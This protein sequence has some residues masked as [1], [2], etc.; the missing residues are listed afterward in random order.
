[1]VP[2]KHAGKARRAGLT[3]LSFSW[4]AAMGVIAAGW[5]FAGGILASLTIAVGF[6]WLIFAVFSISFFRDPDPQVP[7]EPDAVV[8]PGHGTVDV[9]DETTEKVF[10]GGRC[11]R[12]SIFLSIF[13]VHVQNAPVSG[14]VAFLKHCAGK[15]L[16]AMRTDCGNFNE[17][18]LIGFESRESPGERVAVRLIAGLLA[19]RIVPWVAEG[20]ELAKGE[21]TSLIQF[22]SRVDL[23]LPLT[24]EVTVRLGSKVKGGETVIARRT[25]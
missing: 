24:A 9:I 17:N 5:F 23:Y 22:G 7:P 16:N 18:V 15:F 21:R 11:R 25:A 2:M 1:M 8:S 3:I 19:R 20:D 10:M 12:V 14:R 6:L 4:I 13:D